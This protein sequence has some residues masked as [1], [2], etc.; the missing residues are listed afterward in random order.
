MDGST[1]NG[2]GDMEGTKEGYARGGE[3]VW[4]RQPVGDGRA[5]LLGNS[6]GTSGDG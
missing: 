3:G 4:F 2:T 5:I 6:T 1:H